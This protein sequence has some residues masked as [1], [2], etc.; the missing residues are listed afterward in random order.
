MIIVGHTRYKAAAQARDG[1][2]AGARRTGADAG[3]GGRTGSPDN[4]T[5]TLSRWDEDKLPWS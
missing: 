1:G 5:A 3:A 2:G 4:Q